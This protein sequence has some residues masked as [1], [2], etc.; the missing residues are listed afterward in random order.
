M[1]EEL[2]EVSL[3]ERERVNMEIGQ[4]PVSP[5]LTAEPALEIQVIP[6]DP[7]EIADREVIHERIQAAI[8]HE[9]KERD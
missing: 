1:K 9:N 7:E 2:P 6:E 5:E 8:Y 3:G 4:N